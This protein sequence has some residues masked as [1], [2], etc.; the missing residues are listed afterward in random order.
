VIVAIYK[1]GGEYLEQDV[2]LGSG[3]DGG[4]GMTRNSRAALRSCGTA[5]IVGV[6]LLWGTPASADGAPTLVWKGCSI[7]KHAFMKECVEAYEAKTG[8]HIELVGGGATLGIRATLA[9]DAD[10]GGT[11]RPFRPDLFPDM[12]SGG[13][14]TPV[15]W[16]AICFITHPENPVNGVTSQQA[17][18]ILSGAITSWSEVDGPD[19]PILLIYRRQ[20]EMGRFS[21]VGYMT[22]KL[23][24][25]DIDTM[26]SRKALNFR[27]SGLVERKVEELN[28][29]FAADGVSSARRR[30]V[31]I[32]AVDG[33][34]CTKENIMSGRY[35]YFRPLYLVTKGKPA[36]EVKK[37][38]DWVLSEEGQALISAQGTVNL[39]EGRSLFDTFGAWE[40]TDFV[41]SPY[42]K[43]IGNGRGE[44]AR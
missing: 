27:D 18:D 39:E 5:L 6:A 17:R 10:M 24:F 15:A 38:I 20:T 19:E 30:K 34:S 7:T 32:L 1:K 41:L 4:T 22:R 37:F 2:R 25:G 31:K 11:C 14:L 33:V 9:G 13:Y 12:E 44:R 43:K 42:L 16:D 3:P 26:Y 23:L 28:W 40:Q 8:T 21:G 36:G 29:S 35:P